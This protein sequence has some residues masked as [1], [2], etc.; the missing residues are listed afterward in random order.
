MSKTNAVLLNLYK[1]NNSK[2]NEKKMM[3]KR[4]AAMSRGV[5]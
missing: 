1:L 2:A 5:K 3:M 4:T